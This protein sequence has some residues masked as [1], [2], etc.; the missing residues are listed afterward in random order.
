MFTTNHLIWLALCAI[1]I[2]V[3]TVLSVRSRLSSRI[4]SVIFAVIC[5]LSEI[6]KDMVG[7]VP[8]EFG[9]YIL[10]QTAIP[11]HLCS[12]VVFA[13]L[14][15]VFT[16][17]QRTRERLISAVTVIGTV[18]PVLAM[19]IPTE[20][21]SFGAVITYQYFLYHAALMW[22]AL[23]HMLTGQAELGK[24]AYIR[25]LGYLTLVIVL[26]LYINS[27]LSAYGVN[28][29]FLRK[30]PMDGL[31]ILNLDH[32]WYRYFAILLVI[33]YGA[34]TLVHAPFLIREKRCGKKQRDQT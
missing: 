29:F 9:G 3:S 24:R 20:G 11:M 14:L 22:Y 13:V 10:K 5:C 19:L 25:N 16:K 28:Y 15:I 27:A 7:M 2:A 12:L 32:G 23:H 8:S 1:L 6:T 26:M 31:P 30:P 17:K 21:V 34:M 18:A 4:A 33:G